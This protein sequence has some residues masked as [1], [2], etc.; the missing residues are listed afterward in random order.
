[1]TESIGTK[2]CSIVSS[3]LPSFFLGEAKSNDY[4]YG[5]YD[6]TVVPY[7]TKDGV[8]K[9]RADVIIHLYEQDFDAIDAKKDSIVAAIASGMNDGQ[10]RSTLITSSKDCANGIFDIELNYT[11]YQLS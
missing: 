11:I 2:L 10:Y 8:Y 1:M 7:S 4:P 3:I 6:M 5:V 9:Y